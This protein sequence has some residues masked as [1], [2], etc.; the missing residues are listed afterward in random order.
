MRWLLV[1]LVAAAVA[2][3]AH[4]QSDARRAAA[5]AA[6]AAAPSAGGEAAADDS[7]RNVLLALEDA[8]ATAL[9]QR[10]SVTFERLLA[11]DCVRTLDGRTIDRA[12]LLRELTAGKDTV[13]VA[14][15]DDRRVGL[16]GA[17]AVVTGWLEVRGHGAGELF[18]RRYR[19]TDT[20]I[21]RGDGWQLAAA[22]DYLEPEGKR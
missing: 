12:E 22:H 10:D 11:P 20:W 17:T 4:V 15:G 5:R 2:G 18:E 3:A 9:V 13:E 8:W 7:L 16:F 14:T 19:F 1:A 21:R 6:S